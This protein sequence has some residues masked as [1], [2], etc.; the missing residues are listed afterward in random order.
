ME[1]YET[2]QSHRE[3]NENFRKFL[4][5]FPWLKIKQPNKEKAPWHWQFEVGGE[6]PYTVLVNIWPHVAKAQPEGR[7]TYLGWDSIRLMMSI[8]IDENGYGDGVEVLE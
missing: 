6:G 3:N 2:K 4:K 1:L 8:L 5:R 7:E